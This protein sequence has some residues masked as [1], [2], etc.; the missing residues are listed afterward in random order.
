MRI[1]PD[2][3]PVIIIS[4][5]AIFTILGFVLGFLPGHDSGDREHGILLIPIVFS[6][7]YNAAL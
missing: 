1:K 2:I 4:V 3:Y 7:G 5:L 6:S